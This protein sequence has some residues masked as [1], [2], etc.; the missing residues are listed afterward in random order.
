MSNKDKIKALNF[1]EIKEVS[2]AHECEY[3]LANITVENIKILLD[4]GFE[5]DE[6][7][8][9]MQV[10]EGWIDLACLAFG[11]ANATGWSRK[12]GFISGSE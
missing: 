7:E 3:V 6:I 1:I 9:V 2:C 10:D 11:S 4:A 5:V 8:D 12:D